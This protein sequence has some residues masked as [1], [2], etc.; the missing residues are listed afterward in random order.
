[1][2]APIT[3]QL[4]AKAQAAGVDELGAAVLAALGA[5][6][7]AGI[8]SLPALLDLV[9]SCST[10][11]QLADAL[12]MLAASEQLQPEGGAPWMR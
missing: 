8:I 3:S 9:R 4:L 12:V 7:D 6:V 2:T 10:A 1:M 11:A 5:A